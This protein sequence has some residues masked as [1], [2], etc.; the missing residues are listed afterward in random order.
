MSVTFDF[1]LMILERG[2]APEVPWEVWSRF[3]EDVRVSGSEVDVAATRA[4]AEALGAPDILMSAWTIGQL[5][6]PPDRFPDAVV[7]DVESIPDP[8]PA[9]DTPT[10]RCAASVREHWMS[11]PRR[12]AAACAPMV[13]DPGC[14]DAI[15]AGGATSACVEAYCDGDIMD[16]LYCAEAG[17]N[18]H[19][20]GMNVRFAFEIVRADTGAPPLPRA[21]WMP[22]LELLDWFPRAEP[23]DLQRI[24][25]GTLAE[26][27]QRLL[28]SSPAADDAWLAVIG[29]A[30]SL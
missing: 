9:L 14:R 27:H 24:R 23:Q 28:L 26:F 3:E 4:L 21:A 10:S 16:P 6:E 18:V 30:S 15:K 5:L 13:A 25:A 11:V 7:L 20:F 29:L 8:A 22:A 17:G 1:A 2:G 12:V 19:W